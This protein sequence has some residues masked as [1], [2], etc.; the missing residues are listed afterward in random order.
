MCVCA[1]CICKMSIHTQTHPHTHTQNLIYPTGN[2]PI[3]YQS[4]MRDVSCGG[5]NGKAAYS[6][7]GSSATYGANGTKSMRVKHAPSVE[8]M[9]SDEEGRQD[10]WET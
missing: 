1:L 5:A 9:A 8:W 10:I 4:E 3:P 7:I 2:Q 6:S